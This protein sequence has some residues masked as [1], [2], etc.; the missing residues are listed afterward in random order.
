MDFHATIFP[1]QW[2]CG[3]SSYLPV[4]F[5]TTR[6]GRSISAAELAIYEAGGQAPVIYGDFSYPLVN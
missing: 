2:S 1:S 6:R 4:L 5:E 3:G